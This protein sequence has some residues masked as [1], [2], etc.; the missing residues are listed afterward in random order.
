MSEC[1]CRRFITLQG[2]SIYS[3]T[4]AANYGDPDIFEGIKTRIPA[5]RLGTV[6][7]V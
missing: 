1:Q 6:D 3:E 5:Q 2:S 7:E 4:A